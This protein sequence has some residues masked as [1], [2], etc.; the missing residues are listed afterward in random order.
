MNRGVNLLHFGCLTRT[1]FSTVKSDCLTPR[2]LTAKFLDF[3]LVSASTLF[4]C[5][6]INLIFFPAAWRSEPV[7]VLTSI[8]C[9]LVVFALHKREWKPSCFQLLVHILQNSRIRQSVA[10]QFKNNTSRQSRCI[11]VNVY[12]LSTWWSYMWLHFMLQSI[13]A[14]FSR[15]SLQVRCEVQ[16]FMLIFT[17][18]LATEHLIG[19]SCSSSQSEALFTNLHVNSLGTFELYS[20]LAS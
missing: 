12:F 2:R 6:C 8:D 18:W 1:W 16:K 4:S 11:Y 13:S 19:C 3:T 14:H 10:V 9:F 7:L 17:N 15:K 20:E 5:L